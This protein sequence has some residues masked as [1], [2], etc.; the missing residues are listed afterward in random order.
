MKELAALGAGLLIAAVAALWFTTKPVLVKQEIRP[1][2]ASA[3]APTFSPL[4]PNA[5]TK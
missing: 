5:R 4:S 3:D 1:L 2:Q